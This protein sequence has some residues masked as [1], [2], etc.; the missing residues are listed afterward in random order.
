MKSLIFVTCS[1]NPNELFS[2]FSV[3]IYDK[4]EE[5]MEIVGLYR[6][7]LFILDS[8]TNNSNEK[9]LYFFSFSTY[10]FSSQLSCLLILYSHRITTT[11]SFVICFFLPTIKTLFSFSDL[12]FIS[13]R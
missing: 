11:I 1:G 5:N 12:C 3:V 9:Y 8:Q 10:S 6:K 4:A 7:F 2:V 13:H